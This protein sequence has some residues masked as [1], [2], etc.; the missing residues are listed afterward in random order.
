MTWLTWL[1]GIAGVGGIGLAVAFIPGF[2]KRLIEMATEAIS[3][4]L[5][6]IRDHPWQAAVIALLALFLWALHGKRE[7]QAD[8]SIQ[9]AG[10]VA[11]IKARKADRLEYEKAQELAKA[12]QADADRREFELKTLLAEKADDLSR[13]STERT[14][15]AVSDYARLHP[16]RVCRDAGAVS[17]AASGTG[18]ERVHGDPGQPAR[19]ETTADWVAISRPDLDALAEQAVQGAVKTEFLNAAVAAGWAVKASELPVPA[20]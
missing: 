10:W 5:R 14:R 12:K 1:L 17:G 3:G 8:A 7:A 4:L 18:S 16:V 15:I 13:I 20:F 11:E 6:I 19:E 2:G 9:K